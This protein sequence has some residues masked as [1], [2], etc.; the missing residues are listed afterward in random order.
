LS[1][2]FE[3]LNIHQKMVFLVEEMVEN[4][5]PLKEAQKEFKKIYI[6]TAARKY[7]GTKIRIAEALGIH[8]NTL[9]N[10]SRDLK[11]ELE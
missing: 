2:K 8:R 7:N 6:E 9:N 1:K 11:I 5:L 3:G 4:E 10:L